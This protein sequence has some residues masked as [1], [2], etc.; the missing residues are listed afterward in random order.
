MSIEKTKHLKPLIK[1]PGGKEKELPVIF[2]NLPSSF[3]DYYEPFVGGGSVHM[4]MNG[5]QH[6]VNDKSKDLIDFYLALK[7]Q[8]KNVLGDIKSI[9]S[10]WKNMNKVILN[11]KDELVGIY[12]NDTPNNKNILD[13]I[14]N[15]Y[16]E[17]RSILNGLDIDDELFKSGLK[18]QVP[19]KFNRMRKLSAK[20]GSLPEDDLFPNITTA[21]M[22]SLYSYYRAIYNSNRGIKSPC[23]V[24]L[25]VFLRRF[26]YSGMFRFNP[27]GE[28]NV[29][30]GGMGYNDNYLD[31]RIAYWTSLELIKHFEKTTVEAMDFLDFLR[32]HS[33]KEDDFMFLDPPYD[34]EFST[35]DKNE[36][37]KDEQR[38]LA[39]YLLNECRCKWMMVIKNTDFIR[40]LY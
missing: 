15:N 36:F 31:T 14:E 30:Y 20:V 5:R 28:F 35:Y 39:D 3:V 34:T 7:K 1:Y 9:N 13:F 11:H 21:F 8:D 25:Y 18:K 29:P 27:K 26:A 32:L 6:F 2:D 19:A 24:A 23:Q 16:S 40:S 10:S 37:G 4:A 12:K 38:R 22:A 33:P 17:L